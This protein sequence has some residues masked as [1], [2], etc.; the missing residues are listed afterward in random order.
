LKQ[1]EQEVVDEAP[2][3]SDRLAEKKN[4]VLAQVFYR[5]WE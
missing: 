3:R 5:P 4:A 1:L 2:R